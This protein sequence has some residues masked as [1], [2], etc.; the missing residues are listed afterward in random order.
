MTS[1]RQVRSRLLGITRN[2]IPYVRE[3]RAVTGSISAAVVMQQLDYWFIRYPDG[4]YKF[5][6][7]TPNA[8]LYRHGQSWCEELG[9]T[10]DEFRTAFDKIGCRWPSKSRFEI[11]PDKFLDKFYAS[12]VDRRTN[13]TFYF[14]NHELVDLTL[15]RLLEIGNLDSQEI[16]NADLQ[17]IGNPNLQGIEKADSGKSGN[18]ISGNRQSRFR[19]IGNPDILYT[20]TTTETTEITSELLRDDS[21]DEKAGSSSGFHFPT[22]LNANERDAILKLVS[23]LDAV[24]AQNIIDEVAGTRMNG[25]VRQSIVSLT[26]GLVKRAKEGNFH[27]AVAW[28]IAERRKREQS[29]RAEKKEYEERMKTASPSSKE[30]SRK[31]LEK[32]RGILKTQTGKLTDS[33]GGQ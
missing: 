26:S 28:E 30:T 5:L 10:K 14:R 23:A 11:A 6:E 18:P 1:R 3:L 24:T 27:P 22:N 29:A 15:D 32:L 16:G 17:E 20:E 12:Y 31:N 4:F 8:P 19:G 21:P 33:G 2:I 7:P 13:L 25:K 9:F